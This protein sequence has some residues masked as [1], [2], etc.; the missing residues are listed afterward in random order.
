MFKALLKDC[1]LKYK[2][3][4]ENLKAISK[5][6]TLEQVTLVFSCRFFSETFTKTSEQTV[7]MTKYD[8]T[9]TYIQVRQ[10]DT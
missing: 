9:L 4:N 7:R 2:L 6:I 10:L 5:P 1:K 3:I 8:S